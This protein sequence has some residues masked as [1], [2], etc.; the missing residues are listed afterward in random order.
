MGSSK[1]SLFSKYLLNAYSGTAILLGVRKNLPKSSHPSKPT[2]FYAK[3]YSIEQAG[4]DAGNKERES[5]GTIRKL[6]LRKGI[7]L[8]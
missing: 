1:L 7:K 8:R 6:K 3:P 2:T 5:I 4:K